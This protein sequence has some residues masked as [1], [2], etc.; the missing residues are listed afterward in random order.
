MADNIKGITIEIGTDVKPLNKALQSIQAESRG[1]QNELKAVERALKLDP[2]NI[3]LLRQKQDLLTKAIEES[4]KNLNSLKSAKDKADADMASGTKVN[5]EEYRKLQREIVFAEN[6][7]KSLETQTKEMGKSSKASL[8]TAT[9]AAD[10]FGDRAEKAGDKLKSIAGKASVAAAAVTAGFGAMTGKVLENADEIQR[11][12]DITGLSAERIQ[13]LSY[14]GNQLGV[15]IDTVTGAQAKLTKSMAGATDITKGTGLAF[16]TLG[17]NV[18]DSATGELR[19]SNDV[20]AE[21]FSALSQVGNETERD[22]LAMQIFGKSAMQLNPLIKSGKDGLKELTDEAKSNG[23]VMSNEAVAGLDNFGDTLDG[24][25]TSIMSAFG[26]AL[27]DL[28]PK[29]QE[30][31]KSIDTDKLQSALGKIAT[32]LFDV[33]NF[34]LSNGKTIITIVAGIAAG[35]IAWN[36]SAMIMGI[37]SAI[38]AFKLANEGATIAQWALNTAMKANPIGIIITLIVGIVTAL[39]LLWNNC[40]AFRNFILGALEAIKNVFLAIVGFFAGIFKAIVDNA[41]QNATN[42]IQVV[43]GI[44]EGIKTVFSVVGEF[45]SNV[46]SGAVNGIKNVFSGIVGFFKGVWDGI[47]GIFTKIGTAIGDAIGGAFKAVINAIIG[48][49]V[50]FING[51]IKAINAAIGLINKIPGVDIKLINELNLPQLAKGGILSNGQAIVAEAGPE[52]I[53]MVNGKTVVTPL[54]HTAKNTSVSGGNSNNVNVTFN[55]PSLSAQQVVGLIRN[56][57]GVS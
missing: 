35:M 17:I 19:N 24:I 27:Q 18:R 25:K 45:F 1:I 42:I 10:K 4:K 53:Q 22:A 47:V 20:M 46:F 37:V 40:E 8:D 32:V 28:L 9:T 49:A 15:D 21:A 26:N 34:I 54:S 36:V 3:E 11:Q 12:S 13:E 16:K 43:T 44:W 52:L 48:F 23:A 38:K 2:T 55:N 56:E 51:F 5:E 31:L 7:V 39:V 30:L 29:I 50:N 6:K 57:L 41:I 14:A 33:L